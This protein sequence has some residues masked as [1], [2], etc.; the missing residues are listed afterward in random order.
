MAVI[1][2]AAIILAVIALIIITPAVLMPVVGPVVSSMHLL[3]Y[4]C[5]FACKYKRLQ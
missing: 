3:S 1:A 2:L 4:I 5:M